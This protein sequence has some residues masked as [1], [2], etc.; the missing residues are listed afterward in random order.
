MSILV[1][2]LLF[3]M[4]VDENHT[5]FSIGIEMPVQL[6]V[7]PAVRDAIASMGIDYIN[8]Y[9]NPN[10]NVPES[11]ALEITEAMVTLAQDLGLNFSISCYTVNPP[12]S[13]IH[14]AKSMFKED[15]ISFEGVVF[16]ELA[17]CRLLN[18]HSPIPLADPS[19]FYNLDTAYETTLAAYGD[20]HAHY[21][22]FDVPVVATHV[23]PVLLHVAARAGF[24]P[25]PKICKEFYSSVSLAIGMGAALQYERPLWVDVDMWFWDLVP[26]H[27]PEEV[28]SNLMLAYWLG[29]DRVYLEGAGHNL[30][31][32]GNQGTPFTLMNQITPERYQLTPHGEMLRRFIRE[33]LPENP[34]PWSFRDVRP[35]IA[36][37][38]FPDS[39]HG[40]AFT[41][42]GWWKPVLYGSEHLPSTRDTQAW[43][44]IWNVLTFGATG[45][46]GLSFFK[47]YDAAAGYQRPRDEHIALHYTARP[48]QAD[49]HRFFTPLNGAVVFD[50]LVTYEHLKDIPLLFLTGV[51]VSEQ[52]WK[53]L[54]RCV[55]EGAVLVAW[56]PLAQKHGFHNYVS[57]VEIH[58]Q[59]N[60]RVILTDDF[61]YGQV[62]NEI[63]PL[64]GH[65][66]EIR[67]CFSENR[68]VVL[69]RL[70][71][72]EVTVEI[73]QP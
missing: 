27:P 56:G 67:Y 60:G 35:A 15:T 10:A 30:T 72:N 1:C 65:P 52:T 12:D 42:T 24:I 63:L 17:H 70:T 3:T 5:E 29:A 48:V 25:C 71:D 43:F 28:W 19:T 51:K 64:L 31:E 21:A 50:H 11:R 20:L 38:R 61:G 13:S 6:P 34:R 26:G 2:L 22:A 18:N 7:T 55:E 59:G 40:Q 36:I 54:M 14:L 46:D 9:V 47:T 33:Y 49:R 16:D 8:F 68:I 58:Q 45:R 57:G 32:A 37:V 44:Q 41:G 23:W 66:D 73:I 62:V 39:D 69:R 4:S 53:D